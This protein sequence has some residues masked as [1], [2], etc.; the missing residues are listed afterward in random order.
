MGRPRRPP[1]IPLVAVGL[2]ACA[3]TAPGRSRME[4]KVLPPEELRGV[5]HTVQPG[6]SLN[7]LSLRYGVPV[8]DIAE[9]NGL[10]G[11]EPLDKGRMIFIPGGRPLK[12]TTQSQP[13][14]RPT[15]GDDRPT[16]LSWPVP[17]GKI[18][19]RFGK[20]DNRIHEGI[21]ISAKEGTAVIAAASGLVI[22]SGSG[23]RGYGN[24][25]LIRHSGGMVT[26]YAHNRKNL[27]SEGDRVR[28]GQVI[29]EVGQTGRAS[30]SHLHFEVRQSEVPVDPLKHLHP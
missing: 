3:C 11:R 1:L 9:I 28:Q 19:S 12:E 22:Y 27:V 30:A 23:V 24:L 8:V 17:G 10:D 4:T 20:R 15:L 25:V 6:Q 5:W 26:V 21:D 2:L 13:T 7:V 14:S 29:A 16:S 18:S